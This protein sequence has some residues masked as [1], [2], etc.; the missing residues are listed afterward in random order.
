MP[1]IST[2]EAD[3]KIGCSDL[4]TMLQ[5]QGKLL[6]Q[7]NNSFSGRIMRSN[8]TSGWINNAN[9]GAPDYYVFLKNGATLHLEL[10]S[11][12]GRVRPEQKVWESNCKKLKHNYWLVRD[13]DQLA[14]II[15][16]YI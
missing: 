11:T 2:T 4:L 15:N 8:G 7:R 13:I 3:L 1:R 10:K 6:F 14:K 9:K 5:N 16:L 12:T